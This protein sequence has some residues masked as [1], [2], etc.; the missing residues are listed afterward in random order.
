[1]K[2]I[3]TI[4]LLA[5]LPAYLFSQDLSGLREKLLTAGSDTVR[6]D[7][8]RIVPGTVQIISSLGEEVDDSLYLTDLINSLLIAGPLF[9]WDDRGLT[10][11]YRVFTADPG[12]ALSRKDTTLIIPWQRREAGERYSYQPV[13]EK[14]W[15]E[16]N[17]TRS[18]SIS[19]GVSF[20]NTH[21]VM[22]NSTLNLQ[23][24]GKLD[25]NINIVAS[26]SD[27]NIPLQPEGYSQQIHEFDRVF[28]QLY[29]DNMSL[30]A[31]D[32]EVRETGSR[33]IP[34]DRKA[35]GIQ[36]SSNHE[37]GSGPLNSINNS[38]SAA[39]SKGRY[40]RHSFNGIEGSQGPYRLRGANNE[41]FIIVLAGSERVYI[42]GRLL[43][44]GA[45]RDYTI[46]YNLAEIVFTSLM[47]ITKDRRILVEFEY[48]DRNY[49]RFMLSN[50]TG[51]TTEK[52]N[53][54]VTL[55][56]SHDAR[57]QPLRQDLSDDQKELLSKIGDSLH[58]AWVPKADSVEFR[59]DMVLYAKKDTI[60]DGI[61][62]N[63]Y[64]HSTNPGM[65]H[66]RPGFSF[67]GEN[68]GNYKLL[69]NV[70]NGR[71]FGWVA[72]VNG[73]PSGTHDPVILL[74]APQKQQ[75]VSF[76]GNSQLSGNTGA[77]FE[78]ALSNNDI[79]TFSQIDNEDNRGIAFRIGM[80]SSIPAGE[81]GQV[82]GG[83]V[84]YEFS[85]RQFAT[86]GLYNPVEHERDWNLGTAEG[87]SGEHRLSWYGMYSKDT[88]N[89][90]RYNGDLLRLTAGYSGL[91]NMVGAGG[92]KAGFD[93]RFNISYMNSESN[94][95]GTGFFRHMAEI[96][97]PLWLLEVGVRSEGED[98]R[99]RQVKTETL[100]PASFSFNQ[101]EIFLRNPDTSNFHFFTSY[102]ERDDRLSN[103]NRLEP[104]SSAKEVSAGFSTDPFRGGHLAGT[105][106][107]RSLMPSGKDIRDIK[108][109]NS[110]NG[111]LESGL[112][113]LN[114]SLVASGF[115][116][117]GSGLEL[118]KD[119]MYLEVARGQGTHT[120]TDYNENGIAELDEFEIAAFP[121]QANYVRILI[122]GDDYIRTRSN[123]FN[124]SVR[125]TPPARWAQGSGMKKLLSMFSG[126]SAWQT[127]QK[128][129]HS[130]LIDGLNP[131]GSKLADTNL[132]GISSSFRNT[133]SFRG[134]QFAIEYLHQNGKSKS[135]LVNGSDSR[136]TRSDV[137][138]GRYEPVPSVILK[139]RVERGSKLYQSEFFPG[140]SFEIDLVSGGTAVSFQPGFPLQTTLHFNRK[141][142]ENRFGGEKADHHNLGTE[143]NYTLPSMGNVIIRADYYYIEFNASV[144]TPLA[145]EMLEGL[146]PGNN[147]TLVVQL[148][149]NLPG[150]IQMSINY[151]GRTSPGYSFIHTGGMQVRAFF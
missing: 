61:S 89:Y 143:I 102:S 72:P 122:P 62:Y 128:T 85:G 1:L 30:T 130:D 37:P 32:F 19:R 14:I 42:D 74:A 87:A 2:K 82:A 4:V 57:N 129:R 86:T 71:V 23:L 108:P 52:G 77:F 104:S 131:F 98:N 7:S 58:L 138:H 127:G 119:F 48:S 120:W 148:Q 5:I 21:D 123:Q 91:R 31:G 132:I 106:H 100:S 28:I 60:V 94:L 114:G 145:W 81:S 43:I 80:D 73:V 36:F 121:D 51:M 140:R 93:G 101:W 149:Q 38:A 17:L 45:D 12:L 67:T 29:N 124:Q 22:V 20:G 33:F 109:E 134:R 11:R 24:S 88:R 105:I 99:I 142:Q 117:T 111:R 39:V 3:I 97:R 9:P 10:V 151:H 13:S 150:N 135:L 95:H 141:K 8:L 115:Y 92:R 136:Q 116:E 70:S 139:N 126:N 65:A 18:G 54:F 53:Y 75:V 96:S 137:I 146:K 59:S 34:L 35:Q 125:V 49:A 66:Y 133:V 6:L 64:I 113:L 68:K 107:H 16:E 118:K 27:Q 15:K 103:G 90:I 26:I 110:L 69:S 40:H 63:I 83:G 44:R 76:G 25:D 78:F 41:L 84:N 47:P 46:D 112:R 147:V 144:N 79:N 50:S 56:S 55:F